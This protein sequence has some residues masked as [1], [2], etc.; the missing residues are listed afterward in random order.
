MD[1][2]FNGRDNQV[3]VQHADGTWAVYTHLMKDGALVQKGQ[4]VEAGEP[5]GLSGHTGL[6]SG[7]HLHFEVDQATWDGPRSIPTVFQTGVSSTASIVE[8]RTYYSWHPGGAPFTPLLAED[9]KDADFRSVTRPAQGRDVS[10]RY[11]R[12]DRS[13]LVWA[14][15]ATA[16]DLDLTV[17]L[18]APAPGIRASAA[19]PL[20][21]HAPAGTEVYCFRM[22]PT[23][24]DNPGFD[25][26]VGYETRVPAAAR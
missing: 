9:L 7:P 3:L 21:V 22:D 1:A 4:Q 12:V 17:S 19:L 5:L 26:R 20:L 11:E 18:D 13:T 23:G 10:L 25:L 2:V 16:M 14:D 8:G 15:N 6:A 24:S